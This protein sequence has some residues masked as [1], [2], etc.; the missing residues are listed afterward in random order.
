M[1]IYIL[2]FSACLAIFLL[3][4]KLFLEK[5]SIH[6]FKRFYLIGAL[7]LA[8]IIPLITFTEFVESYATLQSVNMESLFINT[9]S[10]TNHFSM[11][12]WS[13][14]GFGVLIF[15]VLFLKNLIEILFK[16]RQNIKVKN[17]RITNVLLQS[18]VIPHTFFRYIFLNRHKFETRQIPKEVL[19][20]EETHA[21]QKHSFD[22]LILEVLQVIFWFNP[23]IYIVKKS[24]K[25]NHEFLAD[26]AV[27]NKGIDTSR[28][29]NILLEFSSHSFQPRLANAINYSSIKKRFTIMKTQTTRK[30]AWVRSI[31][32]LPLL[33]IVLISFS[34]REIVKKDNR[35]ESEIQATALQEKATRKMVVEYNALAKKYNSQPEDNREIELKDLKRMKYIYH[36][37]SDIQRAKAKPFPVIAPPAPPSVPVAPNPPNVSEVIEVVPIS[38]APKSIEVIEVPAPPPPKSPLEHVKEMAD[39]GA[40]FYFDKSPISAAQAIKLVSTKKRISLVTNHT[41]DSDYEVHLYSKPIVVEEDE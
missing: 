4:Y 7:G 18:S 38:K 31:L 41:N 33:A 8:F 5:E 6:E 34:S 13:V 14:Y 17:N 39:N 30:S 40:N 10:P 26:K 9:N 37:M 35:T 22:I 1:L 15:G 11:V 12:L 21:V 27:L 2:K 29:Q 28:Y 20:H 36:T 19:I 16:I 23:L 3:F 24:I 32:F 25:L